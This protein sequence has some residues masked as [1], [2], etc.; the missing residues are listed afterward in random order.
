MTVVFFATSADFRAWLEVNHNKSTEVL[1]GLYKKDTGKPSITW[2]EAV[3]QA[4]CFGWIDGVRK[5]IDAT[6]YTIRF[7]PRK[8]R[9]RWSLVNIKRV[10]VLTD[11]GL[12]RS[13]GIKA[14]EQRTEEGTYSY[15]QRDS[16]VLSD[17]LEQSFRANQKAWAFFQSQPPSYRKTAIWWV[18][19]AKRD[20][21]RH[22]RLAQLIDD[23]EHERP[24]R[25][26]ERNP[27]A[28][29]EKQ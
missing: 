16:A 24:I 10:A 19:S 22:K 6:S 21:T 15:E 8:P 2:P 27:G 1:L 25:L 23:S 9:S 11:L 29:S 14:F 26:L 28:Q 3:D 4:L 20:D 17:G 13:E 5:S 12:M 18:I 7:T